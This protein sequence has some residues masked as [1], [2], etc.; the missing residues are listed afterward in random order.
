MFDVDRIPIFKYEE[1]HGKTL[2]ILT[3]Y[4]GHDNGV[5]V[6]TL[7]VDIKTGEAYLL[8]SYSR[9]KGKNDGTG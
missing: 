2:K 8:D 1:L 7:G 9:K 5:F 3:S 4:E 6:V